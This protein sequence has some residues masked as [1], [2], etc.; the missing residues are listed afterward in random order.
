MDQPSHLK[1]A[2]PPKHR[3]RS[4]GYNQNFHDSLIDPP[5]FDPGEFDKE[6]EVIFLDDYGEQTAEETPSPQVGEP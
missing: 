3:D 1:P 4:T 5:S 6:E 2:R